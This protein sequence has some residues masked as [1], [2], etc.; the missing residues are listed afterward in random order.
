MTILTAL[1]ADHDLFKKLLKGILGTTNSDKRNH[2]FEQLKTELTAHSRAEEKVLYEP[3]EKSKEGKP[4]ALEGFVEHEDADYLVT[5]LSDM[6][7]VE[8]DE[9][10]ARCHVL[11]EMLTHHIEEEE[12]DVFKTARKMFD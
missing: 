10:T 9:W 3:L 5:E 6:A 1:K 12:S 4:E 8:S 11:Q 7:G 2:L